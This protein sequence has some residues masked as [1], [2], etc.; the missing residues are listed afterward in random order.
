MQLKKNL[1][2]LRLTKIIR[3][4]EMITFPGY[5]LQEERSLDSNRGVSSKHSVKYTKKKSGI[6]NRDKPTLIRAP[7]FLPKIL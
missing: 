5:N 2:S 4:A 6:I 3:F 1:D 7:Y